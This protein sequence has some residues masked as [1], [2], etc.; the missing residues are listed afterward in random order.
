MIGKCDPPCNCED[1]ELTHIDF[2]RSNLT[3]DEEYSPKTPSLHYYGLKRPFTNTE[4]DITFEIM[5]KGLKYDAVANNLEA[6][7]VR[8]VYLQGQTDQLNKVLEQGGQHIWKL[9]R[10]I[11]KVKE[12]IEL[13]KS[14]YEK[15]RT[16]NPIFEKQFLDVIKFCNGL[17][18]E[19]ENPK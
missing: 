11:N 4:W 13:N 2:M 12:H 5:E 6:Q 17:L 3:A 1:K 16:E 10:A 8:I 15:L 7:L 18:K 19:L 9:E 14:H